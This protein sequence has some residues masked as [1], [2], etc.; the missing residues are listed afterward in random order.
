MKTIQEKIEEARKNNYE[1]VDYRN[2][3]REIK[4][5]NELETE[6]LEVILQKDVFDRSDLCRS[7]LDYDEAGLTGRG[8]IARDFCFAFTE[9]IFEGF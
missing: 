1:F 9:I 2:D 8:Q 5:A 7:M 6:M 4:T 3:T